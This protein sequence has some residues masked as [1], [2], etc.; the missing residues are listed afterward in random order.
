EAHAE[1]RARTP[2][3]GGQL[4]KQGSVGKT[5]DRADA[6]PPDS[7][8]VPAYQQ[9]QQEEAPEHYWP[10]KFHRRRLRNVTNFTRGSTSE[11]PVASRSVSTAPL[12]IIVAS[13]ASR[14]APSSR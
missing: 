14:A 7:D 6:G 2:Q 8:H 13:S 4:R 11:L 12:R 1:M 10:G 3:D 5:L 9:R